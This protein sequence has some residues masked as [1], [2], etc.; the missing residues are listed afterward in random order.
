MPIGYPVFNSGAQLVGFVDSND[1]VIPLLNVENQIRSF[2]RQGNIDRVGMGAHIA[3]AQFIL[4]IDRD[5][6][7]VSGALVQNVIIDSPA[8]QAGLRSGDMILS[9]DGLT[10]TAE[11]TLALLLGRYESGDSIQV[12]YMREGERNDVKLELASRA[13]LGY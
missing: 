7:P 13:S 2:I 9:I 10:V 6:Y 3:E 11:D 5:V 4:N 1:H 8:W 12:E